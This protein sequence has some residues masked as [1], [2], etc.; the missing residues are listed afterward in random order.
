[1]SNSIKTLYLA[2]Q[3][4]PT[5]QGVSVV[6]GE[7]MVAT[8]A[9]SL[10]LV[11]MVPDTF[12]YTQEGYQQNQPTYSRSI[13]RKKQ[14]VH[15]YCWA[16]DPLNT[17]IDNTNAMETLEA[18]VHQALAYQR[19]NAATSGIM[20]FPQGGKWQLMKGAFTRFG[21]G[22]VIDVNVEITVPDVIPEKAGISYVRIISE[23]IE[24]N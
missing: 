7:E 24:E 18:Q 13:S 14:L 3:N 12:T 16:V 22:M 9:Y 23:T 19:S 8:T 2:L 15:L 5:L 17:S 20:W 21:R 1:M 4:A 6:Y 10:P 11:V